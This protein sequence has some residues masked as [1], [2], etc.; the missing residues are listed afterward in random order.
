MDIIV[1]DVEGDRNT[2]RLVIAYV[3]DIAVVRQLGGS[4]IW[5]WK[6]EQSVE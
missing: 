1:K 4:T 3:D 2:N 6:M 5:N